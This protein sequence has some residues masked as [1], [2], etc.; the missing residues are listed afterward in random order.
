MDTDTRKLKP[1]LFR[2]IIG[3]IRSRSAEDIKI[4]GKVDLQIRKYTKRCR[5]DSTGTMSNDQNNNIK[6]QNVPK[7]VIN[8]EE[9]TDRG[10]NSSSCLLDNERFVHFSI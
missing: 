8:G 10:N 3:T 9:K 1:K 6:F 5:R 2:G 7:I 4:V